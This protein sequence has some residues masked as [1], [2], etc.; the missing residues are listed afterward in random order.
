LHSPAW[1]QTGQSIGWF[2]RR[3]SRTAFCAVFVFSLVVWTTM[4]SA[5]RVLH[6]IWSFGDFSIS[7]R[8]IRQL[9]EIERPGM[10]AVVRDLDAGLVGRLDHRVAVGDLDLPAVDLKRGHACG[11]PAR[12]A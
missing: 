11:A 4:P 2:S 9:P 10:P 5:T 8:H 6:A 12:R 1:S 3:N 7:T